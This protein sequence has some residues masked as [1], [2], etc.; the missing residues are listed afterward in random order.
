MDIV[1]SDEQLLE[2]YSE[3]FSRLKDIL[4]EDMMVTIANKTHVIRYHP[5]SHMKFPPGEQ[6]I[7][8]EVPPNGVLAQTIQTGKS[9]YRLGE[10]ERFGYPFLLVVYPINNNIGET[11]GCLALSRSLERQHRIEEISQSLATSLQEVNAGLQEV[12]SGSQGLS[13]KINTVVKFANESEVKIKEIDT[14]ISA[15]S[16]ISSHSNLLGLNAAIEA[17]R[18]GEQGRGFAVVAEEMRKLASQSKE[19]ATTVTQILTQMKDSIENI[20]SEINTI[21]GIAENQA[22]AT[23]EVTATIEEISENSRNLAQFSIIA[24]ND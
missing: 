24:V 18:A 11:I 2:G 7:G 3:V 10:E 13:Y 8:M 1:L 15:I 17:A 19:S 14:V 9:I 16:D 21:G 22:S 12:A 5:G 20:I 23:E 6:P 4:K